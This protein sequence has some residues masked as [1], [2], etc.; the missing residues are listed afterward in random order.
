[1]ARRRY[2]KHEKVVAVLAADATS[3]LAASEATGIPRT[4][5]ISWRDR[6]EFDTLRQNAREGMAEDAMLVARL[7]W[8]KLGEA[9][10]AG[11]LEPR[12]LVIATGMATDKSQ[13]LTGGATGRSE[14]RDLTGT[15][16]DGE[17][18]AAVRT[19]A[20]IV[21]GGYSG[22]SSSAEDAPEG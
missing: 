15:I 20:D 1:V 3:T 8:Q 14:F 7:A 10:A 12:D 2:T 22:T 9:I 13:L 19:A 18:A 11:L 16:S 6:P 17:L 5:I 21:R 4:T